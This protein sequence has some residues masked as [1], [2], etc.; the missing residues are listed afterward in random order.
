MPY[1]RTSIIALIVGGI[2]LIPLIAMQFTN[3][4]QWTTSDFV[5]AAVL[6]L[7]AGFLCELALRKIKRPN[8]RVA[9]CALIIVILLLVWAELGVGIFGSPFAGS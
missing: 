2:L 6:L 4:V 3:E 9:I 8:M 7:S 1:K 5:V